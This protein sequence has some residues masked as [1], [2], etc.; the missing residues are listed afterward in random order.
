MYTVHDVGYLSTNMALA[1]V[2]LIWLKVQ[3]YL[4]NLKVLYPLTRPVCNRY[5]LYTSYRG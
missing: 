4:S 5:Q 1:E 2:K 3:R